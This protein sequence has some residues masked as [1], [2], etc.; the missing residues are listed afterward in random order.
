[1]LRLVSDGPHRLPPRAAHLALWRSQ[2]DQPD[3]Y[4]RLLELSTLVNNL[5]KKEIELIE[6]TK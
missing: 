4:H 3:Y 2:R 1:L 6:T 5:L